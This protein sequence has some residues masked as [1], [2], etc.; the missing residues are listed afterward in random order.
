MSRK[1]AGE[2]PSEKSSPW[3]KKPAAARA[4]FAHAYEVDLTSRESPSQ[5]L[6]SGVRFAGCLWEFL[7]LALMAE[8][9]AS[10]AEWQTASRAGGNV[11]P[12]TDSTEIHR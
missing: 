1:V 3:F 9:R 6:A 2:R 12:L 11:P 7:A 4:T 5:V 8:G 10:G